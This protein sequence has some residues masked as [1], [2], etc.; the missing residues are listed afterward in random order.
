MKELTNSTTF[1]QLGLRY[2]HIAIRL[3]QIWGA[4]ECEA[5]FHELLTNTRNGERKGFPQEHLVWLKDLEELYKLHYKLYSE[6]HDI[7]RFSLK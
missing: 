4:E 3:K 1:K 5:Y 7:W 6:E 2:P